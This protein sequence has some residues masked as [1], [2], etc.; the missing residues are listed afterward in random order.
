MKI[1]TVPEDS[2]QKNWHE[3]EN[4][5]SNNDADYTKRTFN[6]I[7]I[8]GGKNIPGLKEIINIL[9]KE[10]TN[11]RTNQ[12]SKALL[13]LRSRI[14]C[15]EQEKQLCVTNFL[16]EN[17]QVIQELIICATLSL[18]SEKYKYW[19]NYI[20]NIGVNF[21]G[22]FDHIE[23]FNKY[24]HELIQIDF[25]II[26]DLYTK[27]F[28]YSLPTNSLAPYMGDFDP[29]TFFH[30][31]YINSHEKELIDFRIRSLINNGLLENGLYYDDEL[32]QPIGVLLSQIGVK[33]Y[34]QV[35][36]NLE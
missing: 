23:L 11:Y 8:E 26:K 4:A 3:I 1:N 31:D 25:H 9:E 32:H 29:K 5:A 17:I 7:L 28:I 27:K 2:R 12:T 21:S 16:L 34:D 6:N 18:N 22:K 33:F 35:L 13:D 36:S 10:A 14:E 15:L 19:A 24:I 30:D 20:V